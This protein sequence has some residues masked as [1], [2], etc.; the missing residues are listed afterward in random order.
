MVI[1]WLKVLVL[2][3]VLLQKCC[4]TAEFMY[5]SLKILPHLSIEKMKIYFCTFVNRENW[6]APDK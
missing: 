3:A 6:L 4:E 2:H 5:F 1:A